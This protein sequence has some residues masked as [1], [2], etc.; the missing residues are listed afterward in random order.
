MVAGN[1]DHVTGVTVLERGFSRS[2]LFKLCKT[3]FERNWRCWSRNYELSVTGNVI[4]SAKADLDSS[5]LDVDHSV[6]VKLGCELAR[7]EITL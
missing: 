2:D 4:E 1:G 5:T 6:L 7:V 3:Y